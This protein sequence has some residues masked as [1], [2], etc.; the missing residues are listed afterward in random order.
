MGALAAGQVGDEI[1]V[2]G[3]AILDP[4]GRAA[5]DHGQHAALGQPLHQ[6]G[7]FLQDGQV[8]AEIGVEHLVKAQT[9]QGGGHFA[10]NA[11]A[12]G[13]A[14]FLAQGGAHGGS[15]LHHNMLG[16]FQQLVHGL[17]GILFLQSA[18]GAGH[19]A[20]AAAHAAGIGQGQLPGALDGGGEAA[21]HSADDAHVLLLVAGGH[22]AAAQ[23][24]LVVV[25]HH[26]GA[27]VVHVVMVHFAGEMVIVVD[28]QVAAQ[29]L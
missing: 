5:G 20:L 14:K 16:A 3:F 19:D 24:A 26:A 2:I 17:D 28:A 10:G 21:A 4:A 6:L 12:H 22:A 15:G 9:A 27:G 25:A 1:G 7:A 29:I 11:G 13:N 18:H 8:R 23:H